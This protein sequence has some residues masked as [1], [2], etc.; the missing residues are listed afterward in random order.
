MHNS[1]G[2]NK[3]RNK[4]CKLK[5]VSNGKVS[6]LF[7]YIVV[8]SCC[9]ISVWSDE[10]TLLFYDC[11]ISLKLGL[12]ELVENRCRQGLSNDSFNLHLKC[13]NINLTL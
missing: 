11:E 13:Q 2:K 12:R 1:F 9:V 3:S 6:P 8:H 5:Q 4:K 10:K 7:N